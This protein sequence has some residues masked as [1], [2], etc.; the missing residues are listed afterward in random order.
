MNAGVRWLGDCRRASGG[1]PFLR[2]YDCLTSDTRSALLR[3]RTLSLS[4]RR[5]V[6]VVAVVVVGAQLWLALTRTSFYA[7][8]GY[9][10]LK[11]PTLLVRDADV[12]PFSYFDP[13]LAMVAAQRAIPRDATYTIVV[14]NEQPG[15]EMA[16]GFAI[17][18]YRLWLLPRRYTT[19]IHEA[20][21]A[22]T[23]F[24][25]SEYLGVPYAQEIGLGPGVN[26]VKLGKG[27][28]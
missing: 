7:R 15:Q 19:N 18:V 11:A 13:T 10:N 12:D 1:C 28:Q 26:A 25:G 27:P 5:L 22:L 4:A 20:Q 14:G 2:Q 9:H 21:W 16:P 6:L 8:V 3:T 23:Y 17:S 24:E